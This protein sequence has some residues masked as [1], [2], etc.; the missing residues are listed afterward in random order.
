MEE[1]QYFG[2][3]ARIFEEQS[4]LETVEKVVCYGIGSFARSK[5]SQY[6][7]ALLL[8]LHPK[9]KVRLTL[10]YPPKCN[11]PDVS[12]VQ[13]VKEWLVYDPVF[14][15]GE[16]QVLK[17]VGFTLITVNEV[18]TLLTCLLLFFCAQDAHSH[19]VPK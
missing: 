14:L 19:T 13:A 4:L 11:D 6:Q 16:I 15:P 1:S 17:E 18:H 3:V 9:L 10:L 5:P 7:L 12:P 8:A 2:Q